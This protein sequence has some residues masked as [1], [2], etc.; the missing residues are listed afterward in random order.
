MP[1]LNYEEELNG[2][3]L[4]AV[5]TLEGPVLIIAGAGSGKTRVITFRIA[6]MLEKGIGQHAILAL[7]FTNK[8]AREMESRV[9]ELTGRKLRD[10]TVSTFHA[11]GVKLLR[12]EIEVLGY[13][14]NFSIYDET[15]RNRLI[16]ESLRECHLSPEGVD[17]YKLGQLF[18]NIKIGRLSWGESGADSVWEPV[19]REYQ[20]SLVIYNALDF[21][22][23]LCLP[24]KLFEEEPAILATYHERYRYI[25]VD[26]FQDTSLIQYRLLLLLAWGNARGARPAGKGPHRSPNICV[27]GDD[28]QSIYSWRGAN[29][30]N[31]TRFEEDFPGVLEI[32]LEQNYR[33]TSTI[34]EAANGV[35]SNN[36]GRKDKRLWSGI[37]GGKPIELCSPE[38]EQEEADFIAGQIKKLRH[39]DKLRYDDFGV[40]LRTNSQFQAIEEAFLAENIPYRVSGGQSFFEREEIRDI[41]SYLRVVGNPNDDVNL[42]RI[43]NTPRRGIGKASIAAL[44]ELAKKNHSSLWDTLLRFRHQPGLKGA[45]LYRP[46]QGRLF[47]DDEVHSNTTDQQHH[48]HAA[49]SASG[50]IDEFVTLIETYR[51][52]IL[53]KKGFSHL[54]RALVDSIDY[55]SHLVVEH[56]KNEKVARWK[57]SNIDYLIKSIE[58]W[59]RDE[60]N[61]DPSLYPWLNRIS[62]I[63]RADGDDSGEQSTLGKVNLM[64]IHAAKGLEFPVVFIAG[65]EQGIIPH[66]RSIEEDQADSPPAEA[67]EPNAK[68]LEV[69]LE[70]NPQGDPPGAEL[71]GP[72]LEEERRLFYVAITRARD[73]LYISSCQKRRDRQELRDSSPSP[74]LDEIPPQLVQQHS[75]ED[76]KELSAE[77]FFSMM[78]ERFK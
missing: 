56:S 53:G 15:D 52:A 45:A 32:K 7:T 29:Y 12:E 78:K 16:R 34:L 38:T 14:K 47:Q 65:V 67:P 26:E 5:T 37:G 46:E 66:K 44:S 40:L 17:L 19:Y 28:D 49:H 51:E 39:E 43:I 35:I 6:R 61:L 74:F 30:Q 70:V 2:P 31:L 10:L 25:M 1:K 73:K 20:Q 71:S 50:D 60:D 18:S 59:E 55:W 62:L 68:D 9:K 72:G 23:L 4:Q 57:F 42:L 69:N 58:L 3:Q 75:G 41:I 22:D 13:R 8:A 11:F 76:R 33:S 27:V 36:S 77:D 63:N 54:V 64:T 48:Y 21:D 24:I